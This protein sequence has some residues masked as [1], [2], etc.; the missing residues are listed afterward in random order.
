MSTLILVI[1]GVPAKGNADTLA[2]EAMK[3]KL[4]AAV[5]II[6]PVESLYRWK[7]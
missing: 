7:E 2:D 4:A 1:S 3:Q 5:Q 6:G